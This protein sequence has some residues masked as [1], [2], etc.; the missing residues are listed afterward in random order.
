MNEAYKREAAIFDEAIKLP[1]NERAAYLDRACK[2]EPELRRRIESLLKA[3][4]SQGGF[5]DSPSGSGQS[6]PLRSSVPL[7]EKPGDRIGPYKLLEQ[8]GEGGCGVVYVAEQTEPVRR[9]VA[10]K[11]IKLGMDSKSV[12]A[13]FEAERQALALMDHPNIAKVLDAG[14]TETGRPFFVM[15][16]VRGV[17]ITDYCDEKC[18]STHSR[19]ELFIKVCQA[20]QHAHQKGIIHRDIKPSNILVTINDGV[21]VPKV[22][23][24]GVAKATT[25][26]PLTEKTV[27]TAFEQFIGTPAYMSPEQAVMTSLDIDTRSDIYALGVL[28]YE[29]LTGKTPFDAKDLMSI[30]LDEMRRII[31]ETE[32][33]RPSACLNTL[34][35]QELKT[36]AQRRGLNVPKLVSE[37][38]SDLDWIVMKALE[39][40][41]SR[42]YETANGLAMDV[43][44]HMNNEPVAACPPSRLY[45]L[46]KL[47]R[48]NT[49]A[50]AASSAVAV[51]LVCGLSMSTVMFLR[52][53]AAR[54]QADE[55]AEIANAVKAFLQH[56]LLSQS[57]SYDQ[58]EAGYTP[59]PDLKV[60]EALERAA[61]RIDRF[62]NHP[63][64]EAAIL[65]TIGRAFLD[66]GEDERAIPHLERALELEQTELGPDHPDTLGV[67]NDLGNAY[68]RVGEVEKALQIIE[69]TVEKALQ[70]IEETLKLNQSA[71]GPDHPE[72]LTTMNNLAEFYLSIAKSEKAIQLLEE[73][74]KGRKAKLGPNHRDT[75]RTMRDLSMAYLADGK[76]DLASR[77]I[78][79]TL[80]LAKA[81][82]G[83][84]HPDTLEILNTLA[85]V[86]LDLGKLDQAL[87]L[88]EET[89]ELMKTRLGPDHPSTLYASSSLAAL[90]HRARK[91]KQEVELLEE[92]L[93]LT[94]AKLG[95]EHPQTVETMN[96]LANA[97]NWAD[98]RDLAIELGEATLK[99]CEAKFGPEHPTTW[100]AMYILGDIYTDAERFHQAIPLLEK[101]VQLANSSL[102]P[103]HPNTLLAMRVLG[104]GYRGAGKF[105]L[106]IP[107]MEK[108]LTLHVSELGPYHPNTLRAI[109]LLAN[110]YG[111]IDNQDKAL[112]LYEQLLEG[113]EAVLGPDHPDTL[114]TLNL[115]GGW[116]A[117]A[118]DTDTALELFRQAFER[119]NAM[120]GPEHPDT[121]G[122][123]LRIADL[124]AR[125]GKLA[126]AT[127]IFHAFIANAA[128][129][130]DPRV[131]RSAAWRLAIENNADWRNGLK[132]VSLAE[133]AIAHPGRR[134]PHYLDTLAAAYAEAGMFDKAIEAQKEAIALLQRDNESVE[135]NQR[136]LLYQSSIPYRRGWSV[137][138]P[139]QAMVEAGEFA[140]VEPLVRELISIREVMTPDNWRTFHLKSLL[141][142]SLLGQEKYAEAEPFLLAGYE[143]MREREDQI[144]TSIGRMRLRESLE[145]LVQ[146]YE[147]TG[148]HER[149]ARWRQILEQFEKEQPTDDP[150]DKAE[151]K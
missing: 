84:E 105:D 73:T 140:E 101:A 103:D 24:F 141:G 137:I 2:D 86:H 79:E 48:R 147:F 16:L 50:F 30:G 92:T 34:T 54:E 131:L 61:E 119:R 93:E 15:E 107:L 80:E 8:I 62:K 89:L 114:R 146:L 116:Y 129:S 95:P 10:L 91:L 4:E 81:K 66:L 150:E 39:K 41:R 20:I 63:L 60:R 70:T 104:N 11:I 14:A 42:R 9:R 139:I 145:R 1:P 38:R 98:R 49:L 19:L 26:Q 12:V 65:R 18:L 106:A 53:R 112:P 87:P 111:K 132:A 23:D 90:Y 136:L 47:V 135:Y 118:G 7:S 127:E 44:R 6:A 40:D 52:E 72:T 113:W 43:V 83:L 96:N 121:I 94:K 122:A 130:E 97:Y 125:D 64:Q 124:L 144:T 126:E 55:Q 29:L 57:S 37:L 17:R 77:L 46:G 142:G 27:Y 32:P 151:E 67:M 110:T 59:D 3:S 108:T 75:L 28:L 25:G 31:R 123:Q 35:P 13:R 78:E 82:L 33:P 74:L 45:R 148:P 69:E 120:L 85:R 99:L 100:R 58:A 117:K 88:I 68:Y 134:T 56:D 149:A 51:S 133:K 5:L 21:A 36:V 143:G 109:H 22:I 115:L 102:G 71:L 138:K 76:S 128:T